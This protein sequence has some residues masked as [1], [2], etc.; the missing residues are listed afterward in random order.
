M[1]NPVQLRDALQR[2]T[3]DQQF[4][5]VVTPRQVGESQP[6]L[7]GYLI[8]TDTGFS[9]AELEPGERITTEKGLPLLFVDSHKDRLPS[10]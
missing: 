5:L 2:L 3:R 1:H 6:N 8:K 7:I 4:V 9:F 10:Q